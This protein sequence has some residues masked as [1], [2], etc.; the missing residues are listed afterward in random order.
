MPVTV[1][2]G[3]LRGVEAIPIEVEVDLLRRLPAVSIVGLAA[4]AVKESAERV[5]SA[6]QSAQEEFPRKRV[7]I[8]LMPADVRKEGTA[9][10][11]PIAL[12]ILAAADAIP[13]DRVS[14]VLTAGELSLSGQLR[15]TR[16]AL[17][18]AVLAR[19]L[20]KTLVLPTAAAGIA[21]LVPGTRVVGADTLAQVVGWLR[22]EIDLQAPA[23]ALSP[24]IGSTVDLSEVRGQE[25]ARQGLEVAAAGAHHLLLI[26]PPGCGK[27]M[28]AQRL[29]TILPELTV[30]EA[31]SVTQ[32]HSAA[33]LLHQP[34]LVRRR[35]F[36]APHHTVTLAGMVGDRTLRPGEVSLA[37]HGVL[38]LDE[39][40]EFQR[41]VIEALRQPLEDGCVHLRRAAGSV[42]HPA[43]ITLVLAANPC[44]CGYANSN[45]A[46]H[47]TS[48]VIQR[49]LRRLS[50]PVMDRVDLRIP[51]QPVP[52]ELLMHPRPSE[53]SA[54]V[55]MRVLAAR[56]RQQ[57]RGQSGP[58]GR[59]RPSELDQFCPLSAGAREAL[60]TAATST[61]LSGRAVSRLRKVSRTLA[62]L[63]ES[64][65]IRRSHVKA[66]L[67]FRAPLGTP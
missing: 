63:D 9:L 61:A 23:A 48:G 4:S 51:L 50:G 5:R 65:V 37:H 43:A 22:G 27:S 62:D 42:T 30:D 29:P 26:G 20:D 19:K 17:P 31:L 12:G 46:C 21:N 45:E 44:P 58:N 47:C 33:G 54:D 56:R 10:D 36:R 38:F 34:T 49:Y 40:P 3:A 16:G 55:R 11:L 35:P 64:D 25:L 41:A 66:A 52:G 24:T 28:L 7:V 15:S 57:R 18:L 39:A 14:Q 67:S 2:G 59:L 32:V 6:L 60:T 13:R 8:N 1:T 53:S